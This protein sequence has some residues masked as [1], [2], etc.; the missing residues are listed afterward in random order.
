LEKF[1]ADPAVSVSV[2]KIASNKIF[3]IGRV[4]KP[5]DFVTGRY[6]DV[7]QALSLAG[8]LTPFAAENDIKVLRRENGKDLV[9]PFRYSE[10]KKGEN[11]QQNIILKAGDVVVVP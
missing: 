2:L 6:V 4:N 7:L 11:L 1:I 8:G 10:V 9:F 3:V 5:G